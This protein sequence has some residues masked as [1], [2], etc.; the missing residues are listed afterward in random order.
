MEPHPAF[1]SKWIIAKS[2][3][4][5]KGN[6]HYWII[7]KDFSLDKG[8][9]F[10]DKSNFIKENTIGPLNHSDFLTEIANLKIKIELG[11]A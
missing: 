10:Q 3:S 5:E 1:D 4:R 11:P 2:T 6:F 9:E 8:I 7:N